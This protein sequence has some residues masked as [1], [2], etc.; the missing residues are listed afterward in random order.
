V[1]VKEDVACEMKE[2]K[3]IPQKLKTLKF[4]RLSK[5]QFKQKLKFQKNTS[6]A[7]TVTT[8]INSTP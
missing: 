3:F 5:Q 6:Q 8:T 7:S 2:V 4:K 1:D